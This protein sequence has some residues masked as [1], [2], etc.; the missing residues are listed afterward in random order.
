[1]ISLVGI[2]HKEWA[3]RY[4]IRILYGI[5]CP[6][7]YCLI[8]LTVPFATKGYRGLMSEDHGCGERYIRKIAVPWKGLKR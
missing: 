5:K 6:K 3:R 7:C 1:M 2:D 4:N 8:F